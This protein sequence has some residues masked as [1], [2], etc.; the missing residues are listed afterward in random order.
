MRG[1]V[2]VIETIS[3]AV[4]I[5]DSRARGNGKVIEASININYG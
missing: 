3:Q 1:A 5:M 2:P 4:D